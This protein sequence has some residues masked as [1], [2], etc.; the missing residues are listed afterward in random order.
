M[1][2]VKYFT[3]NAFAENTYLLYD[4]TKECVLIDP[5]CYE[6]AEKA[7]L[8]E[9]I[10]SNELKVV[11]LFNTHCH[12][13]HVLGNKFVTDTFE[14][15]L[16]V[17]EYE[18]AGFNSVPVYAPVYG[19]TQYAPAEIAR[20]IQKDEVIRF[21]NSELKVLF[22][23][24]HS[25]GHV[26]F[27]CESQGFCINGDVLFQGS[28]GRTDLPGGDFTT[29]IQSIKNVMFELPE[30]TVVYCGHGPSTTI[31]FEKQH[32]PFLNAE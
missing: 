13:D 17:P 18:V 9:F 10:R 6:K 29:L 1:V 25:E 24:G 12:I 5:G 15:G 28:I 2:Q 30:E 8:E 32:N 19:F 21:G 16:E 22:V 11:R 4:E 3:F 23:P 27:Y 26:A 14:V 20:T 31:G 7:E